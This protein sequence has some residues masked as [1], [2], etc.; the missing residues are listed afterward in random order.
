MSFAIDGFDARWIKVGATRVHVRTGGR[1]PALLLVHGYPQ[2]GIMWRKVAPTLARTH[3]VVIPDLRGYGDSDKPRDG[4][5]KKTM[6]ADLH[7]VMQALGHTRY[8]VV[9]HDRGARV[10]HRLALDQADAVTR[11]ALLDIVP[12]H[13]LFRDTGRELAAAYWHWFFFQVPDLPEV[14]IAAAPEPFLRFMFRALSS[15]PDAIEEAAFA[16]Y[17]RV[18]CLPGTI[19][20]GLEDYRAAAT[21][22][23]A[24]DAADLDRR[25][26]CPTLALWGE[27]GKMHTLFDVL[28]T[29]RDK[30]IDVSGHSLPCGHFIPEEAPDALLAALGP[31]LSA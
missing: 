19:R 1:G 4:Y 5:D 6:A 3:T 15:V 9:G 28:A 16:E 29:W 2:S 10:S 23:F 11:L 17:L 26:T 30:A 25:V 24:D 20:A 18:F 12:T 13:T 14:M 27:H 22:D 7:G 31:F 21:R 8:A